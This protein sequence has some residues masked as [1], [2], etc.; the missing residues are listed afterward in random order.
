MNVKKFS[1]FD[2]AYG[3]YFFDLQGNVVF[4]TGILGLGRVITDRSSDYPVSDLRGIRL[5]FVL[6]D[7]GFDKKV[8]GVWDRVIDDDNTLVISA[9]GY[10][11]SSKRVYVRSGTRGVMNL[12][13]EVEFLHELQNILK[14]CYGIHYDPYVVRSAIDK[15]LSEK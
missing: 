14:F 6:S 13:V 8:T 15:S 5:G 4:I 9:G 10:D 2:I 7:L 11:V 3:D 12:P 1:I